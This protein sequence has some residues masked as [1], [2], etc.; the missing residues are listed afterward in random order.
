MALELAEQGILCSTAFIKTKLA[1][2]RSPRRRDCAAL[3][4]SSMKRWRRTE[5]TGHRCVSTPTA[6]LRGEIL[7]KQIP[8]TPARRG[9]LPDRHRHRA[10][11]GGPQLRA[12]RGAVAGQAL[13][14]DRP[15][16]RRPRRSRA[17]A[18]RLFADP[19]NARDRRSAGVAGDAGGNGRSEERRCA[20]QA[21]APIFR[22]AYGN[23]LIVA[24]GYGADETTAAFARAARTRIECRAISLTDCATYFGLWAGQLRARRASVMREPA[25]RCPRASRRPDRIPEAAVAHRDLGLTYW[26]RAISPMREDHLERALADFRSRARP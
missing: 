8:P 19:G 9:V 7:L 17:R 21:T 10:S 3:T 1:R 12:A 2:G 4:R 5:R 6:R 20:A 14:I 15:P 23:A 26:F 24:R 11:P 25:S 22:R 13:P 18:Q 16:R